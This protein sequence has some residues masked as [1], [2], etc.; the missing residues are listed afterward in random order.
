MEIPIQLIIDMQHLG[1]DVGV[2]KPV[3]RA[4]IKLV[5]VSNLQTVSYLNFSL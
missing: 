4:D 1:L 3:V 2:H 5:S